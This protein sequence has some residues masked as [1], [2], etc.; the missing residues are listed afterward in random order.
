MSDALALLRQAKPTA[1][2]LDCL[3]AHYF[4]GLTQAEIADQLGIDRSVVAKHIKAGNAKLAKLG[5]EPKRAEIA[6]RPKLIHTDPEILDGLSPG[7]VTA[8]W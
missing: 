8:Q 4:D 5:L 6:A 7:E 2:Q 1:R 3:A